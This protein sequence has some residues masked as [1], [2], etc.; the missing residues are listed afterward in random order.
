M[1][2]IFSHRRVLKYDFIFFG[3]EKYL[4]PVNVVTGYFFFPPQF[5]YF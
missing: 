2:M 5:C 3:V 4:V 1:Q